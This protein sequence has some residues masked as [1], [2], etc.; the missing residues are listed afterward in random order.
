VGA[1]GDDVYSVGLL[2][3]Q[4]ELFLEGIK[5]ELSVGHLPDTVAVSRPELGIETDGARIAAALSIQV[6]GARTA[7]V[8]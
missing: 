3:P 7:D 6:D 8:L 5:L 4:E 1:P 2:H